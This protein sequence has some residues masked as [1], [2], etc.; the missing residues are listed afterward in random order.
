[1]RA[2]MYRGSAA[3]SS[4]PASPRQDHERFD[5][6]LQLQ[7]IMDKRLRLTYFFINI[8]FEMS[9]LPLPPKIK[10]DDSIEHEGGITQGVNST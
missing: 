4:I 8:Y 3:N 6:M 10:W 2:R 9:D 1:M 5:T 7:R